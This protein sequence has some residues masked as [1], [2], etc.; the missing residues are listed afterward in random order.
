MWEKS[1][2]AYAAQ[3]YTL[4][5]I[6]GEASAT[7][8]HSDVKP[9]LLCWPVYSPCSGQVLPAGAL[10]FGHL[11]CYISLDHPTRHMSVFLCEL[12]LKLGVGQNASE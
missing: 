5:S 9:S 2:H 12:L 4:R 6:P 10:V 8:R 7:V 11:L 3:T 1:W